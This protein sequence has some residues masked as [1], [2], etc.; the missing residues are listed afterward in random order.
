MCLQQLLQPLCSQHPPLHPLQLQG[1]SV[2]AY[3][4]AATCV[5]SKA[6]MLKSQLQPSGSARS[7][8]T[9]RR[10]AHTQAQAQ[11]GQWHATK[12]PAQ[13]LPVHYAHMLLNRQAQTCR[14]RLIWAMSCDSCQGAKYWMAVRS[15]PGTGCSSA[16]YWQALTNRSKFTQRMICIPP[17]YRAAQR[18][19][20]TAEAGCFY[21]WSTSAWLCAQAT[22]KASITCHNKHLSMFTT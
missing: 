8:Q 12:V 19:K 4:P 2:L 11:C 13:Q 10:C 20:R 7:L 5:D 18:R 17:I 21:R 9:T 22:A 6:T 14:E 16:T 3:F 1:S 15:N